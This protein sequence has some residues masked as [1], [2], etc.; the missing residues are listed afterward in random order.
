MGGAAIEG[1]MQVAIT[2]GDVPRA[3]AFYRDALG[4]AQLPIPAPPT[5]AFLTAGGVR[6]MLSQP[7]SGLTP[8]GGTVVYYKVGDIRAA[9]AAMRARG[10]VFEQDPHMVAK[11]PDREVWLAA[12]RDPDGNNLALMSEV[13]S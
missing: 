1:V 7:E 11:L 10:A 8:G 2:V 12:T 6:L 9:V 13:A 3:V 5:M 4:M